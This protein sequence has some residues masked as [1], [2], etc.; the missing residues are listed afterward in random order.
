MVRRVYG[1]ELM[2]SF[3]A[4]TQGR[5]RH[6]FYGAGPGVAEKLASTLRNQF[7]IQVA[8]IGAPP[9]RDLTET[10]LLELSYE[11][12]QSNAD[13]VWIGISTPKQDILMMRL[14]PLIIAPVMLGVGAAFDFNSGQKTMAPNS[15]R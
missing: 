12:N 8:G 6:F 1:P 2:L 5:Y 14:K 13:V 4:S 7:A 9:F 11:I 15:S 3:C 10:E